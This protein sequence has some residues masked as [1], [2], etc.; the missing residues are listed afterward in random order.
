MLEIVE[1]GEGEIDKAVSIG[2]KNMGLDLVSNFITLGGAKMIPKNFARNALKGDVLKTLK[3][4][5]KGIGTSV[6]APGLGE[7][8]TETG[9]TLTS[10]TGVEEAVN[11]GTFEEFK[12]YVNIMY[13][14][15]ILF[16]VDINIV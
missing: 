11:P 16:F 1:A 6:V 3:S 12:D 14:T 9:Q 15:I 4:L 10:L 8:V 5:G 2:A 13:H 7:V